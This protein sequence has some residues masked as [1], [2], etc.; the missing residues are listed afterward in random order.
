MII[1]FVRRT[2]PRSSMTLKLSRSKPRSFKPIFWRSSIETVIPIVINPRPPI[3]I[4]RRRTTCPKSVQWVKV[5]ATTSPVTQVALAAV[6]SAV[7]KEVCSP[8]FVAQGSSNSNVPIKI[9]IKKPIAIICIPD[10]R[11]DIFE[12]IDSVLSIV[13]QIVIRICIL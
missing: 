8:D 10:S 11:F 3:C 1:R 7:I 6:N 5:S 13:C 9:M 12:N 4:K 2:R